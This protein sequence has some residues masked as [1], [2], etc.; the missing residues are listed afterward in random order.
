[1]QSSSGTNSSVDYAENHSIGIIVIG[2]NDGWKQEINI[3]KR[4]NQNFVQVPFN[5]LIEQIE[6]K[7]EEIGIKVLRQEESYTS[8]VDHLAGEAI[9]HHKK[10]SGRHVKRGLFKSSTGKIIN[11]D[12]N[13]AIGIILKAFPKAFADGIE[14]IELSPLKILSL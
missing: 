3:G 2:K 5:N 10:Y 12:I 8:K 6:Y 7:A 14:A 9:R 1:M 13:G 4:N 11:A